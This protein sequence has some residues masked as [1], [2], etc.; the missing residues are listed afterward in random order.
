MEEFDLRVTL[1]NMCCFLE[2][3]KELL[4]DGNKAL[5]LYVRCSVYGL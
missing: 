2:H 5:G 3:V 1:M 4:R